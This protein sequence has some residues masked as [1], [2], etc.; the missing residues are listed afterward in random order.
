MP[1]DAELR[2]LFHDARF[3]D[4]LPSGSSIDTASVNRRSKRR[5]LPQQIGA[6]S[7]LTLAVAGIG[8]ASIN[9]LR[10]FMPSAVS[11]AS[12]TSAESSTGGDLGQPFFDDGRNAEQARELNR[13]G[14]PV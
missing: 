11:D 12:Y 2:T 9:G 7:V 1:T 6:G 5:R 13:C 8:V 3:R 14:E 10:S 4:E